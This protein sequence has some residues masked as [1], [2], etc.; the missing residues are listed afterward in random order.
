MKQGEASMKQ[1]EASMKQGACFKKSERL[2]WIQAMKQV[3]QV[4]IQNFFFLLRLFPYT[5]LWQKKTAQN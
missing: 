3:K 5:K 1:G 4:K 2:R